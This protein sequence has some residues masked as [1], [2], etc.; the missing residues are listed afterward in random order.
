MD[1]S[2]KTTLS[3]RLQYHLESKDIK[4]KY[5]WLRFNPFF[6]IPVLI[7]GRILGLTVYEVKDGVRTGYHHFSG[8]KLIRT[9]YPILLFLDLLL[10]RIIKVNIPNI[11]GYTVI[12][13]RYVIDSVIDM[14]VDLGLNKGEADRLCRAYS[15][16]LPKDNV[17]FHI[18]AHPETI[19]SRRSTLRYDNTIGL[20][21]DLY[22]SVCRSFDTYTVSNNGS[23][24]ASFS[25]IS[26][27]VGGE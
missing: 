8:S 2:G 7:Y 10:A 21:C 24:E 27:Y 16:L 26:K 18:T 3:K 19:Y 22:P 5:V 4:V 11:L 20:R 13:D 15:R 12:C 9:A 23:A 1:G 25:R 6:T 17:I 14:M